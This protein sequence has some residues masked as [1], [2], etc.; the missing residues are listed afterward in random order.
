[1]RIAKVLEIPIDYFF[2]G[3]GI[4][5]NNL[6]SNAN[7]R[8]MANTSTN[9]LFPLELESGRATVFIDST[10]VEEKPRCGVKLLSNVQ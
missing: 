5:A 9:E 8:P 10:L 1:V 3:H 2:H 7:R 6:N 4:L